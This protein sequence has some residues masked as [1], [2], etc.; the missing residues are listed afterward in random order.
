MATTTTQQYVSE[1]PRFIAYKE[2]LLQDASDFVRGQFGYNQVID[3]ETGKPTLQPIIDPQTGQ[4]VGPAYAPDQFV[5]GLS[6]PE[7]QAIALA[8]Q[9]IGSYQPFL[10][11]GLDAQET[12]LQGL[13]GSSEMFDPSGGMSYSPQPMG[14]VS[15]E[16]QLAGFT[17]TPP[18]V[19]DQ[20]FN[21]EV[22]Q[23]IEGD[24]NSLQLM[25][26][27]EQIAQYGETQY[28]MTGP[29]PKGYYGGP[30]DGV[31]KY[32][33]GPYAEETQKYLDSVGMTGKEFAGSSA[34]GQGQAMLSPAAL[35][36]APPYG[37][38]PVDKFMNPYE[39]QVIDTAMADIQRAGDIQGQGLRAQA[40]GA[41]AFGGSRS[42][43]M[44]SELGRNILDQQAR[45]AGQ[46]RQS[47]YQNALQQAQQAFEASK[48]RGLQASQLAGNLGQGIA[49]L[50][51]MAQGALQSDI[52]SLTSAG[53][54]QRGVEQSGLDAMYKNMMQRYQMPYQQYG[55]LGDI[56]S[57]APSTQQQI[58][59]QVSPDPSVG[60]QIAGLGIAGLSAAAGAQKAG[61]FG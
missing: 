58:T 29:L 31:Y 1:D 26:P 15:Y 22:S 55:F 14:K 41:G 25:T 32:G 37:Q 17:D 45:T 12:A 18:G 36:I 2:G 21:Q 57:G 8:Q 53:A 48:G 43:I 16:Q 46:M 49:G 54:L 27:E 23:G 6:T 9:G 47:G 13:T 61:L 42:G 10:Q 38:S 40:V 7:Q 59:S 28:G 34:A 4:P 5:A 56:Y 35:S 24:I 11:R 33:E 60:Q 50:G 52:G 30:A 51:G 3:P 20:S 19:P 44:E 39:R